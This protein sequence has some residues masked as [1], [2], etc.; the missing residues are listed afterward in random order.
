MKRKLILL[1]LAALLLGGWYLYQRNLA[2][3]N[4]GLHTTGTVEG[5]EVNITSKVAG[6]IATLNHREG[7]TVAAGAVVLTLENHDFTAQ[8]RS[9]EAG[10]AKAGAEVQVA[11]AAL[12]NLRAGLETAAAAILAAQADL[13]KSQVQVVDANRHLERLRKLYDQG[14]L[15]KESLDVAE[16]SRDSAVAAEQAAAARVVAAQAGRHGA[17]AQL[18]MAESQLLL[19]RANVSQAQADLAFRQAN[20]AET[21]ITSPLRG[22]VAYRALEVGETVAPGMT[23]LTLVDYDHLTIRVDIDE[24]RLGALKPGDPVRITLA[25]HPDLSFPGRIASVSRYG[26]FA[27]QRDVAAGRQ[28]LRTFRVTIALEPG[29]TGLNPGMTVAVEIPGLTGAR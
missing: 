15:A 6:R 7:E 24:S 16:T 17:E 8:I 10:V 1:I 13:T 11:T 29:A 27:T 21:S 4:G 18:H 20:L 5:R 19:A 28:D 2:D 26:D 3:T 12:A 14:G 23:V 25:S 22:V 9:A